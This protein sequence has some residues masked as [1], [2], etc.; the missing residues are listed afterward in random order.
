[1]KPLHLLPVPAA[2]IEALLAED[3]PLGDLT[4]CAL[5]VGAEPGAAR[6]VARAPMVAACVEEAARILQAA[7]ATIGLAMPS[8]T[9]MASRETLLIANGPAGALLAGWKVAQTLMEWAS[10]IATATR[11]I[12]AA[13]QAQRPGLRVACTRK[14]APL[15]RALAARAVL[16]GGGTMHRLGLS[17]TILLFPEHRAFYP[18]TLADAVIRLRAAAPERKIVVE[19][20]DTDAA[21]EAAIAGADVVQLEKFAPTAVRAVRAGLDRLPAPRP[22]LA[23]AGGVT[24]ANAAAYAAAGA[25]ILVTSAPYAAPPR[26]VAVTITRADA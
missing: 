25:D 3:V 9:E 15:T 17:E 12:V 21:L 23:A 16:A 22:L 1:V 7:G 14:T 19:V 24:A 13:G 26:D 18:G 4:T 10:G 20:T 8:G 6:F 2:V 11:D 5:G